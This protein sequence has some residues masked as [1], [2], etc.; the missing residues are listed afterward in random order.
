MSDS[1]IEQ[2]RMHVTISGRVQG[3][4][5][6][7]FTATGAQRLGLTGWVRN[8]FNGTVETVAE[9]DPDALD[10]FLRHIRTGPGPS[11][12]E[13]VQVKWLPATGEFN[14]FQV[15]WTG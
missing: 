8:R 7:H 9:G 1:D 10:A 2:K 14:K 13:D 5:F 12:V 3:V 6:R 4:G 15:R 11:H